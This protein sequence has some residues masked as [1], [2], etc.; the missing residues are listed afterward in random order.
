M[1]PQEDHPRRKSKGP[2][3]TETYVRPPEAVEIELVTHR[4]AS[5]I[6]RVYSEGTNRCSLP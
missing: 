3:E 2:E 4:E 5:K 6:E 1:T